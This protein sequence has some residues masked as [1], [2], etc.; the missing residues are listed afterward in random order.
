MSLHYDFAAGSLDFFT[1]QQLK[2]DP[3]GQFQVKQVFYPSRDGTQVSMYLVHKR[4]LELNGENPALLY[5]YGGFN[6]P[7]TPPSFAPP[8]R[9]WWLEQGGIYA[10]ANLRGGQRIWG[11]RVAPRGGHAGEQTECL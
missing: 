3:G 7:I 8:S 9:L 11:G 5:G 2:F 1:R 6:I 10:V 4:G